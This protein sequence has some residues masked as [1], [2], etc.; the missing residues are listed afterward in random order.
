MSHWSTA[1]ELLK[2]L[3][4]QANKQTHLT[5]LKSRLTRL[6]WHQKCT[7][8]IQLSHHCH[9]FCHSNSSNH[10][11]P[12][13]MVHSITWFYVQIIRTLVYKLFPSFLRPTSLTPSTSKVT[14]LTQSSSSFLKTCPYH[15]SLFLCST[16]TMSSIS[17]CCINSI[18]DILSIHFTPHIRL[19]FSSLSDA[20]PVRNS[21]QSCF[22][23]IRCHCSCEG[24]REEESVNIPL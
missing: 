10:F 6:S 11:P 4:K 3:S 9:C 23:V 18:Q 1:R 19:I 21:L 2:T 17:N 14:H 7:I 22:E 13:T 16:F 12:L 15:H 20:M 8:R 24:Y 5:P